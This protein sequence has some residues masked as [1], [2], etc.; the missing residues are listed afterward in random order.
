MPAMQENSNQS[1]GATQLEDELRQMVA[2]IGEIAPA[3][4]AQANFY[5]DLG[6][7]SMKAMQLLMQLEDRY[8]VQVPDDQFVEATS[9]KSLTAMMAQLGAG[10]AAE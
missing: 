1:A 10:K 8:G 2:E 3:F 5:L 6:V 4:D 9:L 7:P